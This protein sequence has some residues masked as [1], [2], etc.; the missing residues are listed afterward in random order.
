MSQKQCINYL[1][2]RKMKLS[3]A[4]KC[5]RKVIS[6]HVKA[7]RLKNNVT[8]T[9]EPLI[10]SS[11]K[12]TCQMFTANERNA[13]TLDLHV[14]Q[15]LNECDKYDKL[16]R[17][18]ENKPTNDKD[19]P[20][21]ITQYNH[22]NL[23]NI[24]NDV[25]KHGNITNLWD[26]KHM[27]EKCMQVAKSHFTSMHPHWSKNMLENIHIDKLINA[28]NADYEDKDDTLIQYSK[29]NKIKFTSFNQAVTSLNTNKPIEFV[30]TKSNKCFILI[31]NKKAIA[32]NFGTFKFE[33]LGLSYFYINFN[34]NDTIS[35]N[36]NKHLSEIG[37]LLPF[38]FSDTNNKLCT[39]ITERW[40]CID[41]YKKLIIHSNLTY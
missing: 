21:W 22:V 15:F 9:L 13:N 40:R 38:S 26:G 41:K 2:L 28:L 6:D 33:K 31:K 20:R 1:K 24:K 7:V 25:I 39:A 16:R 3:N 32:I 11:W 37:V 18:M 8:L 34:K 10:L 5:M 14:K 12:A 30:I 4:V 17:I 35:F 36:E 19:P 27:G 23:L 29:C